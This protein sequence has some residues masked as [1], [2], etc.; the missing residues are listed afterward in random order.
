MNN[1][2]LPSI[3]STRPTGNSPTEPIRLLSAEIKLRH[4]GH[5]AKKFR[6]KNTYDEYCS[7]DCQTCHQ[8]FVRPS[9]NS[10]IPIPVRQ[11]M[12]INRPPI[13]IAT[14]ESKVNNVIVPTTNTKMPKFWSTNSPAV[15]T[16][17]IPN[18]DAINVLVAAATDSPSPRAI[19]DVPN[20][21]SSAIIDALSSSGSPPNVQRMPPMREDDTNPPNDSIIIPSSRSSPNPSSTP[22][23]SPPKGSMRN[24]GRPQG[25]SRRLASIS[26][27]ASAEQ[28][29][30]I[31]QQVTNNDMAELS[32]DPCETNSVKNTWKNTHSVEFEGQHPASMT[33]YPVKPPTTK[34]K[35]PSGRSKRVSIPTFR[36]T[37]KSSKDFNVMAAEDFAKTPIVPTTMDITTSKGR[38][39]FVMDSVTKAFD[40]FFPTKHNR[41]LLQQ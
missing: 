33:G 4:C 12:K 41:L 39:S 28:Q 16:K 8:W 15:S 20:S 5:C 27:D 19:V 22:S 6:V 17:K 36:V 21:P 2:S 10:G 9:A 18:I 7:K 32:V 38:T 34:P 26:F 40:Y 14:S 23:P 37:N 29:R 3:L 35:Q 24:P 11:P 13:I 25:A 1:S 30:S 31:R